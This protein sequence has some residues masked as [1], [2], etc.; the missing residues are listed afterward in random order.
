MT[1][2]SFAYVFENKCLKIDKI[3]FEKKGSLFGWKI[4][5]AYI[6]R[7]IIYVLFVNILIRCEGLNTF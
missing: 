2:C 3:Y 1:R 7:P 6:S 5:D 4:T